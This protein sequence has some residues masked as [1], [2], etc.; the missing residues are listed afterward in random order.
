MSSTQVQ[1]AIS[2]DAVKSARQK[3]LLARYVKGGR[4]TPLEMREIA[5]LLGLPPPV[6][7]HAPRASPVEDPANHAA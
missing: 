2:S 4:M 5:P 3:H 6:F 1:P 7:H